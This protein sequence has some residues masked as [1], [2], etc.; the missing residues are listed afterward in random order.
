[1]PRLPTRHIAVAIVVSLT[2]SASA[3][4]G[5]A[6]AAFS[7]TATA[8]PT[9]GTKKI[10][11]VSRGVSASNLRDASSGAEVNASDPIAF[12]GDTRRAQS[13]AW[14]T[15]GSATRY[16]DFDYPATLPNGLAAT[17]TTFNFSYAST[18]TSTTCYWIEVRALSTNAVLSAHGSTSAPLGCTT[19]AYATVATPLTS[20][21]TTD[22]ADDLRI[23]VFKRNTAAVS[24]R[25]DAATVSGST[26]YSAFTLLPT[27]LTD[28]SSGTP[29][30]TN[31]SLATAGDS[32]VYANA[33]NWKNT[34]DSTKYLKLTFPMTLPAAAVVTSATFTHTYKDQGNVSACYQLGIYDGATLLA[35]K[36][37][38]SGFCRTG[39]T[40]GTDTIALPE[41]TTGAIANGLSLR[42]HMWVGSS[43]RRSQHDQGTLTLTYHLD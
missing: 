29:T 39:S 14:L 43:A 12:A 18:S 40:Y 8:A 32:F 36:G 41:V 42:L 38:P 11:T 20:V 35:T 13:S 9:Y 23:R 7:T 28:A 6:F 33:T 5:V 27:K 24:S 30:A 25:T 26:P 19:T 1:M 17:G 10:F 3:L 22:E 2:I 16:L 4:A 37:A 31:W 21:I 15:M 34:Y